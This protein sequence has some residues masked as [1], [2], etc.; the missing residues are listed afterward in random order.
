VATGCGGRRR[1]VEALGRNLPASRPGL[2]RD[3]RPGRV[4]AF[5]AAREPRL[6]FAA[7]SLPRLPPQ[8]ASDCRK[9][10]GG[11]RAKVGQ[12]LLRKQL[13]PAAAVA[14]AMG[15]QETSRPRSYVREIQSRA[16]NGTCRMSSRGNLQ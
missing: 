16:A 10:R 9:C 2:H 15:Q 4:E 5:D 13:C 14:P 3:R 11:S 7:L 6:S 12:M 8:P 1:P